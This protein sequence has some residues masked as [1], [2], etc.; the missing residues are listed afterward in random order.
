MRDSNSHG[1]LE[2]ALGR[3]PAAPK[4]AVYADSTNPAWVGMVVEGGYSGNRLRRALV[5]PL[6]FGDLPRRRANFG[7]Y[8]VYS[9]LIYKTYFPHKIILDSLT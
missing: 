2:G 5:T 8:I 3:C 7:I 1:L 6:C 4:A 9:L